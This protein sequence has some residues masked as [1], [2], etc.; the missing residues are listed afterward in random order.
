MFK[1]LR[2]LLQ[3]LQVL[4]TLL[5][6]QGYGPWNALNPYWIWWMVVLICGISFVGYFAIKYIGNRMGT[7]VT[8]ITGGLASST[9]VT[10]SM[11][12]FARQYTRKTLFMA[13]VMFASSIMF[14]RIVVE[15]SIVNPELLHPLWIPL[16]VMFSAVVCGAMW[17]WKQQ[18]NPDTDPSVEI[19]NPF[20]LTMALKFGALL[21]VILILSAAM[22]EWFGE[23]GIYVLAVIS[24]LADVDAITLSLSRM[25]TGAEGDL[26]EEVAILGIILAAATNTLIKGFIFSFFVGIKE[27]LKLIGLLGFSVILGILTTGLIVF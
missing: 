22:K 13:G 21:A 2:V 18:G 15:V 20:R 4:G 14:I 9:A 5:P 23:H 3:V 6:N 24:G 11:A 26:R 27:S 17:L 1:V 10:F 19:K 7:L 16:F 8:S 12:Q 25:S